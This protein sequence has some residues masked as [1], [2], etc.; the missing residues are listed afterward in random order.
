VQLPRRHFLHMTAGAAVLASLPSTAHAQIYPTRPVRLLVGFP[1]GGGS[2]V[3]ARII[4]NGLSEL[5]GQQV[6]VENKPGAG[7]HLAID[8]AAHA[9]RDGYTMLWVGG[10]IP[11]YGLMIKSI[12]YDPEA[13]LTPV[14]LVGTYPNILAVPNASPWQS[15]R[16]IIAAAKANPGAVTFSSPGIGTSPHLTGVLFARLAGIDIRHVPYRGGG[17]ALTDLIAAR[18]DCMFNTA[19]TLLTAIRAGQV[20]G[21][22]VTSRKQFATA[23][24][25]PT[26]AES[27]VPDLD[28]TSWYALYMPANSPSP[29]VQKVSHDASEILSE[30]AVKAKYE[31]LGILSGGSTPAEL[32]DRGRSEAK[33]WRSVMAAAGI[34]PE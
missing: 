16:D 26:I 21:L 7:G 13:D 15:V 1:P 11:L 9:N 6:I 19:G 14:T 33:L 32:A 2:D 17:P 29:I 24:E 12:N 28:V 31:Q 25:L 10:A 27:G 34:Q 8:V 23:A 20:R 4:A 30:P 18:V 22:A 5:W 3:G